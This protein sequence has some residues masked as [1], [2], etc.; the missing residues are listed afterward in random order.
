MSKQSLKNKTIT[1]VGWSAADAILG[2][3]ITFLVGLIL[4]R[5]LSPDEYGLIGIVTIFI[6]ILRGFVDSGFGTALVRKKEVTN[7]EYN[8]MF[9]TNMVMSMVMYVV[10][11]FGAPLIARF[12]EREELVGL[13]RVSGVVLLFHALAIVQ[14]TTLLKKIDFKTKTK[15]SLISSVA[16]GVIGIG[17]AI[18]G[19]GVWALVGQLVSRDFIYMSCL[20]YFNRWKPNFSFSKSSL[21]YMWGFGWKMLVSGLIDRVWSELYQTVVAKFYTPAVL[22]QYSRSKEY[23]KLLSQN[24]TSIVSRVSYPVI[25]EVQDNKERMVAAY[26]KIIKTTMFISSIGMFSMG[27]VAEPLIYCLVGPKW[28]QAATFLP[29]ICIY[30]SLFPLHSINL[31]MLKVQGRSDLFLYLEI[32]KKIIGIGPLCLGIFVGIYWMLVG[33]IV[34]GIINYFLNSYY[35]GKKLNYSSWMQIKDI[36]P[37][38]GIAVVIAISVYFIKYLP[39]SNFIILPIQ[40]VVGIGVFFLM[41][42]ITRIEEYKELRS[43]ALKYFSKIKRHK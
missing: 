38:Y 11:F 37:S 29:L 18:G 34:S 12:F 16:S 22:G 4:A 13:V 17:M 32:I 42:Q 2:S 27:A 8:T 26:R 14:Y 24:I 7:I 40:I 3:G 15:A 39:I 23:A 5:I 20:W 10:L 43:I 19:L 6:A 30:M 21:R 1:G 41:V 35:T 33:S 36:A 25:A 28:H 9:I 31:N